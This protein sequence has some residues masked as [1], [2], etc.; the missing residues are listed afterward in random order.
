MEL[1]ARITRIRKCRASGETRKVR[2]H[3]TFG[4]NLQEYDLF[5]HDQIFA[6]QWATKRPWAIW[7]P[8]TKREF[9]QHLPRLSEGW[10][11]MDWN[12]LLIALELRAQTDQNPAPSLKRYWENF[13]ELLKQPEQAQQRRF[14][15]EWAT[16]LAS[17]SWEWLYAGNQVP[18]RNQTR[19]ACKWCKQESTISLRILARAVT[20]MGHLVA[21]PYG[22]WVKLDNGFL[23]LPAPNNAEGRTKTAPPNPASTKPQLTNTNKG[24]HFWHHPLQKCLLR[25]GTKS[26]TRTQGPK[27]DRRWKYRIGE[28]SCF[29]PTKHVRQ[30]QSRRRAWAAL[31]WAGCVR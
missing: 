10:I 14:T 16:V 6:P 19:V 13:L 18:A 17:V 20:P 2:K 22:T 1:N 5:Y 30:R 3:C 28:S 8:E 21:G 15:K 23:C 4:G 7:L 31:C 11:K 25:A 12:G 27:N 9:W 24:I 29:P 26:P